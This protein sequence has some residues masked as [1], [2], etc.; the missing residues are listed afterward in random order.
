M[1]IDA[2]PGEAAGIVGDRCTRADHPLPEL[3]AH[4]TMLDAL[5]Y[6]F[7]GIQHRLLVDKCGAPQPFDLGRR[8]DHADLAEYPVCF[9]HLGPRQRRANLVDLAEV[10]PALIDAD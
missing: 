4:D 3:F 10:H 2:C 6:E 1:R 7:D 5:A 9:R 8:L